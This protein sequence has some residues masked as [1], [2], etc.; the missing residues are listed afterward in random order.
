MKILYRKTFQKKYRK[1]SLK[2]QVQADK[3]IALFRKSPFNP[4]L[5]NH[6]LKGKYL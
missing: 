4:T 5:R 6:P 2:T 1:L 3:T